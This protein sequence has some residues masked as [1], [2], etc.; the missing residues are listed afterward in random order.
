MARIAEKHIFGV[1]DRLTFAVKRSG[2][3]VVELAEKTGLL[4]QH[5]INMMHGNSTMHEF[6]MAR[7]CVVLNISAD[8]LLGLTSVDARRNKTDEN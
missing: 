6:A 3:T 8:W 2:M 7:I 1:S 4:A 5:I